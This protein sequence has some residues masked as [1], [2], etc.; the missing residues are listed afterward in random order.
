MKSGNVPIRTCI[1]C[2]CKFPKNALIR[3]VCRAGETLA[4][5]E[6]V[7]LPGRGAYVCRS[8]PCI[9]KAFNA[10][11]RIN[12]LLRTQLPKPVIDEFKQVLLKKE[13]TSE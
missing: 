6:L 11:K 3:F 12:A 10:S 13:G 1:G 5:E 8:E 4:V 9:H 7:K 2:R